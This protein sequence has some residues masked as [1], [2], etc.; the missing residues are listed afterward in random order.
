MV[1]VVERSFDTDLKRSWDAGVCGAGVV[2][3]FPPCAK[4]FGFDAIDGVD[5][6]LGRTG[7][8]VEAND[9]R[10]VLAAADSVFAVA[11]VDRV[12]AAH[13]AD[14]VVVVVPVTVSS[15]RPV[16]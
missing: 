3:W 9:D 15:P 16:G 5:L 2:P 14:V 11:G 8:R 13:A 12:G 10:V 6:L 1:V 7:V 4:S